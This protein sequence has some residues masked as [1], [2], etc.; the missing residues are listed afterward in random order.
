V[1]RQILSL[2]LN[3]KMLP[4]R[5]QWFSG[6]GL[7]ILT[8]LHNWIT[9][10]NPHKFLATDQV[11]FPVLPDFLRSSG[12]G[13]GSTQ[14]YEYNEGATSKKKQQLR[15]R[16]SEYGLRDPSRWPRG[17]LYPQKLG[18]ISPTSSGTFEFVAGDQW[19]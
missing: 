2:W 18:L 7:C 8:L 15:S 6:S 16:K 10:H 17:T 4:F 5:L 14:P 3:F 13:T 11:R 12:S 1:K 9:L 19:A